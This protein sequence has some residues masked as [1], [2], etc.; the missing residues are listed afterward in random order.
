MISSRRKFIKRGLLSVASIPLVELS[1]SE[2]KASSLPMLDPNIINAK[3]LAYTNDYK[4]VES[5]PEYKPGS[6]CLNCSY[7][8]KETGACPIFAGFGVAA[9]GWCRAW[10]PVS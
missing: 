1:L 8:N 6:T 7:F 10:R 4:T 5:K 2:A 3:A 9:E